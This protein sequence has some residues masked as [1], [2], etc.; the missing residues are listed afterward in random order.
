MLHSF[1]S[2]G[3]RFHHRDNFSV[4]RVPAVRTVHAGRPGRPRKVLSKEVLCEMFRTGRN[5]KVSQ[6]ARA[7]NVHRLTVE[8][9]LKAYQ[10]KKQRH[11]RLSDEDLD[12]LVEEFKRKRPMSGLSYLRGL[13]LQLGLRIQR[14]RLLTSISRVDGIRKALRKNS[15][16]KRRKYV[17]PGPNA[18]W[19]ID[20]HHELGPWGFIVHASIDGCD[21]L[22]S[23]HPYIIKVPLIF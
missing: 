16:I 14:D 10:I 5:I 12:T 2:Q 3:L 8:H 1:L 20:G 21:S 19:H 4:A 6:A 9:Y 7:L 18:V 23:S 11:S 17:S 15:V 13:L 22:V